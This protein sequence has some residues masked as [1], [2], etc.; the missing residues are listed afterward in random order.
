[1]LFTDGPISTVDQLADYESD[2]RQ[3]AAAE[4]IDLD[5]KLR[6]AQT[7]MGVELLA[8]TVQ[9]DDGYLLAGYNL[10]FVRNSFT[11]NQVVVTDA[12]RLWHI[13]ATLA[14]VYR[15]AYNRKLNDKYL[16]KWNEYRDLARGAQGQCMTIGV[17]LVYKPI[18]GA[19][20]PYD[21]LRTVPRTLQRG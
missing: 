2:I 11:L 5:S 8:T 9:P 3:L 14:T 7:E 13:F 15:D 10:A 18:P 19:D 1:M 16:P 17:G 12:L 20:Q 6:L 21:I 4:S